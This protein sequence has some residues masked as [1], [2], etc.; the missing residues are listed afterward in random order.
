MH[1]VMSV[2]PVRWQDRLLG[3]LV[4]ARDYKAKQQE[5]GDFPE[6]GSCL[7][8]YQVLD[9]LRSNQDHRFTRVSDCV[10]EE[11]CKCSNAH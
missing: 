4:M 2:L 8:V 3:F 10:V 7:V 9:S 11:G 1:A 6:S 5:V